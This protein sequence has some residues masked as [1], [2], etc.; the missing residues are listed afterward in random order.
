MFEVKMS[1]GAKPGKGGMLPGLKVN[2]EIARVRGIEPW[3][4]SISPN[5]HPEIDSVDELLD[6]VQ[7]VRDVTQK[8]VGFKSVFGS[9]G[10]LEKL[11]EEV[12]K[13]GEDSAPD[14]ITV[15]SGDGGTGAAPQALMDNVG[16]LI[17]DAL[18]AVVAVL[19]KYNLKDRI[20]IIAGGKLLNPA[21]VAWA[22]CTGADFVNC[23]RG[24]MFSIGCIQAMKCNKD[25]CP[26]GVTTHNVRLQKG[27]D[28]RVKSVRA[29]NY[30]AHMRSEIETIAHSCGV[31]SP[32]LLK[33]HHARI[34][35]SDGM[36]VPL[37]KIKVEIT[38]YED[39][40]VPA[41]H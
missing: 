27:L 29:A 37:D 12:D 13:R 40:T 35:Q 15:D 23:G 33:P 41:Q 38:S 36:S 24:F 1:Q 10:W 4:D 8:P 39:E 5:R 20:R 28:P 6:F 7:H 3:Q 2:E 21:D 9:F 22:L 34:V 26:T 25:T 18:P 19:E 32:R 17:R 11:C 31:R 16:L 30:C 14:F